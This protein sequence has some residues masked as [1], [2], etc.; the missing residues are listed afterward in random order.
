MEAE[1]GDGERGPATL[2]FQ[3]REQQM[4]LGD[5]VGP[6]ALG[7]AHGTLH[8]R[9]GPSGESFEHQRLPYFLCT[10]CRAD[11]QLGGDLLPGPALHTGTSDLYGFELLQ[12]SPQ[13]GHR[14]QP[15]A[16]VAVTGACGQIRCFGHDVNLH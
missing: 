9:A 11:A 10:A 3:Q 8:G 2:L 13:C 6:G 12:Q 5:R 4:F 1:G 7:P 16:R 15:D 14:P